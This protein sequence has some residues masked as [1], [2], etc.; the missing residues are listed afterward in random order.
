MKIA[1]WN[2]ERPSKTS[3]RIPAIVTA[4]KEINPDILILTE[5]NEV[6][7]LGSDYVCYHTSQPD[8]TYY[9]PGERR[10]GIYSKYKAIEHIQTFKADT[11]ICVKFQTPVG[12]LVVYGTIIGINGNRRKDFISD[13][14]FQISDFQQIAQTSALCIGGDLNISFGDNYYFTKDG[15]Q[16]LNNTFENL[17]LTNLTAS[18]PQNIDQLILSMSYLDEQDVQIQNWN[19]DKKLSDHIG[20][21]IEIG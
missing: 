17:A 18:I 16:K 2:L 21:C 20:V 14:D 5:T 1:T 8:E 19:T 15:R 7:D 12:Y 11:S 9:K 4:L 3:T 13:L 6:I 10:T